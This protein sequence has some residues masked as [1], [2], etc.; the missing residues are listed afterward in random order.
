MLDGRT[1]IYG[2]KNN[3]LTGLQWGK[4]YTPSVATEYVVSMYSVFTGAWAYTSKE[5]TFS[6]IAQIVVAFVYGGLQG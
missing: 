3:Y 5:Y 2:W 4:G 1:V 6:M